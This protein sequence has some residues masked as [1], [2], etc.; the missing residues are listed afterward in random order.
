[1]LRQRRTQLKFTQSSNPKEKKKLATTATIVRVWKDA[2]NAYMAVSVTN[3]ST[4]GGKSFTVEYIGSVPL[5]AIQG[6]TT[7]QI[8]TALTTAVKA[9]RDASQ[10]IIN[11][12]IADVPGI[13]GP[14]TI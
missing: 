4:F 13:T 2:N 11:P 10:A 7:A 14:V 6:M 8:K 9:V 5:S 1:M 12:P 3:D